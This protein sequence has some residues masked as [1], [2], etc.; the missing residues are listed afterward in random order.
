MCD[1]SIPAK[2]VTASGSGLDDGRGKV[3]LMS[4]RLSIWCCASWMVLLC[5]S[6]FAVPHEPKP[7]EAF[8]D[9]IGV[10]THFGNAMYP[11][12]GYANPRVIA[13]LAALGVRHVR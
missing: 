5:G 6:A 10:N 13:K 11:E 3:S 2:E 4:R 12:N 1:S 9:S 7:A 8:V